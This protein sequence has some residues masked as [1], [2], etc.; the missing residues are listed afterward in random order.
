MALSSSANN[1]NAKPNNFIQRYADIYRFVKTIYN[2]GICY[3]IAAICIL[4]SSQKFENENLKPILFNIGFFLT[5]FWT[6]FLTLVYIK[7]VIINLIKDMII[8][9]SHNLDN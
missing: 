4:F 1:G 3:F 5:L 7:E 2:W 6:I 8:A 9:H